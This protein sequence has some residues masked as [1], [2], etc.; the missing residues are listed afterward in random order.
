MSDASDFAARYESAVSSYVSSGDES[1]LQAAYELGREALASGLGP[2][3]LFSIHRD[4]LMAPWAAGVDPSQLM[5]SATTF[6]TETLAPFQMAFTGIDETRAPVADLR[7]LITRQASELGRLDELL[8]DEA[9]ATEAVGEARA[10]LARHLRDLNGLGA[11]LDQVERTADARRRQIADIVSV[12]EQERRRLAGEIHDDALQA[13]S[14]VVMR[15]GMVSRRI[16]DPG[17][18]AVIEQLEATAREAIRRL[19]RLLAGLQPPE[20]ERFGLTAAVGS[21][22]ERLDQDFAIRCS[23]S[24]DLAEEPGPDSATVAFRIIQEALANARKH[25]QAERIDVA[26]ETSDGG[27]RAR[28][29]DDGV[30]FDPDAATSAPGTGHLGLAAMRERATLSGGQLTISSR[31]GET[32]VEFWLPNSD[33]AQAPL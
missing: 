6:F 22:L 2:L 26:L 4:V 27:V 19:R 8:D 24:S 28:V 9:R 29:V 16:S 14:A 30:G 23:F 1:A 25:A 5:P 13:M 11:Q 3:V 17:E 21:A 12:Q 32:T 15:L 33:R 7:S 31:P 10:L 18:R 20:L